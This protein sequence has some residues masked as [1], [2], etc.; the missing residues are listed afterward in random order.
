M[1]TFHPIQFFGIFQSI[2][3]VL[4]LSTEFYSYIV[5]FE[6]LFILILVLDK[7]GKGLNILEVLS[8]HA[9]LI[10]LLTPLIGYTFFT[11]ENA[12]AKLWHKYMS[13]EKSFYYSYTIPCILLFNTILCW[14]FNFRKIP[15]RGFHF[16]NYFNTMKESLLKRN[17]KGHWLIISGIFAFYS[18]DFVPEALK[19]ILNLVFLSSFTGFLIVFFKKNYPFRNYYIAIFMAFILNMSL[20]SGMFT[21]LV[22]M[23]ATIF[24]FFFVGMEISITQKVAFLLFTIFSTFTLQSVKGQYRSYLYEN[25]GGLQAFSELTINELNKNLDLLSPNTYFNAYVRSNQG[26]TLA[27]VMSYIPERKEYDYGN[28]LSTIIISSFIPRIFWSD[29]PKAGGRESTKYYTGNTPVGNTSMNVSPFGEG[30]GSF[31][32][33]GGIIYIGILSYLIRLIYIFIFNKSLKYPFLILWIPLIFLPIIYS[34]ETD[35]LQIFNSTIKALMFIFVV[36]KIYPSF[37]K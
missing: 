29:K 34:S 1:N 37:F 16:V 10:I 21:I 30:Y 17:I 23:S 35:T 18:S 22:Y 32:A 6:F 24:T 36:Y 3:L 11:S 15:D 5:I 26:L 9:T 14:P 20:S 2:L 31:G 19:N 13:V 25:K 4:S 12:L 28:R 8:L 33:F 7:I 27:E